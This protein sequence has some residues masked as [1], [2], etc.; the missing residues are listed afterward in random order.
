MQSDDSEEDDD[1]TN[2]FDKSAQNTLL[3]HSDGL[4]ELVQRLG[5]R[6]LIGWCLAWRLL[7]GWDVESRLLIC[8]DAE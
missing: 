7:I 3:L 8:W 2:P 5:Q 1:G 6:L 4:E